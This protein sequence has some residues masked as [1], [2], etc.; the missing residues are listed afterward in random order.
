MVPMR[1][2][3]RRPTIRIRYFAE[4]HVGSTEF[5]SKAAGKACLDRIGRHMERRV[6]RLG[7]WSGNDVVL[8][9]LAFRMPG[10]QVR[11][12]IA[13]SNN[14][15]HLTRCAFLYSA[16][17]T[18]VDRILMQ[19]FGLTQEDILRARETEDVWQFVMR[20]APREGKFRGTYTV[21]VYDRQQAETLARMMRENDVGLVLDPECIAE[22]G[23][24]DVVRPKPGPK[25]GER[26]RASGKSFEERQEERRDADRRRKGAQRERERAE[27]VAAG[28]LRGRG[29][30][31]KAD[32]EAAP[33]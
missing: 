8:D 23:I 30:P 2:G 25:V 7:F 11:A 10:Q 21:Y 3:Q 4:Q 9:Y 6:K 16:K 28:M 18:P 5:W 32:A 31:R 14:Y 13:G 22:A 17:A 12:R 27:K 19:V 26:A 29:R 20:G 1:R 24:A 33:P 15:R